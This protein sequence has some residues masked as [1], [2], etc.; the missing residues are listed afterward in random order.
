MSAHFRRC[1][2]LVRMGAVL[3]RLRRFKTGLR[4]SRGKILNLPVVF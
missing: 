4:V 3:G 1:H 2:V